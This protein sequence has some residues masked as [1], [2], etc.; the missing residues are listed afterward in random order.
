MIGNFEVQFNPVG[1]WD[2]IARIYLKSRLNRK[3][4]KRAAYLP[5]I[6]NTG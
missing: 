1:L 2:G 3:V 6:K 5:P 4:Q